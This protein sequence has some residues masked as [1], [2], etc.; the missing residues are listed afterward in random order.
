MDPPFDGFVGGLPFASLA[1]RVPVDPGVY[2]IVWPHP[3][4]RPEFRVS[5]PAGRFKG[6]DPSVPVARLAT[7]WIDGAAVIYIGKAAA[8]RTRHGGLAARLDEY[9]RF[10]AGENVAHWGGR[11]VWQIERSDE[12]IV[13]WRPVDSPGEEEKRMLAEFMAAH[14]GRLPFANL[15]T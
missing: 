12:L 11:F 1:G 14:G 13:W 10:G 8:R 3:A 4:E 6:K 9:R 7:Q 15:R 2:V 5:S